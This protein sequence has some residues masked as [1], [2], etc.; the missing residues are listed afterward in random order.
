MRERELIVEWPF[1][2]SLSLSR[3]RQS[4]HFFCFFLFVADTSADIL[5]IADANGSERRRSV[6]ESGLSKIESSASIADAP[7]LARPPSFSL[8][9]TLN[10][11]TTTH[12][13]AERRAHRERESFGTTAKAKERKGSRHTERETPCCRKKERERRDFRFGLLYIHIIFSSFFPGKLDLASSGARV[14]SCQAQFQSPR[15]A[16]TILRAFSIR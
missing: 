15:T 3:L 10:Q 12:L 7:S 9:Q 13:V 1:F 8:H 4:S 2:C 5:F 11:P 6:V 16:H 14:E